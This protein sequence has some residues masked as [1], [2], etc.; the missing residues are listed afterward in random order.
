LIPEKQIIER[1][2]KATG[3]LVGERAPARKATLARAIRSSAIGHVASILHAAVGLVLHA[4]PGATIAAVRTIAHGLRR[5]GTHRLDN[6]H[7]GYECGE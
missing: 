4:R 7:C 1:G 2:E 5:R 6:K 3:P